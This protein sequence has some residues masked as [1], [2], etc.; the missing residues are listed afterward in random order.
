MKTCNLKCK[1]WSTNLGLG[2]DLNIKLSAR[3]EGLVLGFLDLKLGFRVLEL[4]FECW[5]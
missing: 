2:S 4:K 3:L 1:V 5:F